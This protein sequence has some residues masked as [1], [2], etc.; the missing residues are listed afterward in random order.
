M[1]CLLASIMDPELVNLLK[2]VAYLILGTIS[3]ALLLS[4]ALKRSKPP[5]K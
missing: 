1:R 5:K 4:W 3:I 2:I